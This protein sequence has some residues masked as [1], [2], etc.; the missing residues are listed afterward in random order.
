MSAVLWLTTSAVRAWAAVYTLGLP[1]ALRRE[2]QAELESDLWEQLHTASRDGRPPLRTAGDILLRVVRGTPADV[3]WRIN[4]ARARQMEL[5][6]AQ[7]A[8]LRAPARRGQDSWFGRNGWVVPVAMLVAVVAFMW[9]LMEGTR[10]SRLAFAI[11]SPDHLAVSDASWELRARCCSRSGVPSWDGSRAVHTFRLTNQADHVARVRIEG[12]ER[13]PAGFRYAYG[14]AQPGAVEAHRAFMDLQA[15][16]RDQFTGATDFAATTAA[17]EANNLRVFAEAYGGFFGGT[18]RNM[19]EAWQLGEYWLRNLPDATAC[20]GEAA[21]GGCASYI[22]VTP[23]AA[24]DVAVVIEAPPG[25][26]EGYVRSID[27]A[28]VDL[29]AP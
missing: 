10:P 21:N 16:F 25:S 15:A 18:P 24:V 19:G 28:L 11:D 2:R 4:D 27:L 23:G 26:S 13:L 3:L 17:F 9:W 5:V 1:P 6:L 14:T 12:L 29:A 8:S 7:G 20:A 22:W